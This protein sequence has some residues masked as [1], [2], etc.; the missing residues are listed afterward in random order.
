[1]VQLFAS[2]HLHIPHHL[3]CTSTNYYCWVY[4][5]SPLKLI[6]SLPVLNS[7]A[8]IVP[9]IISFPKSA[10]SFFIRLLHS[11]RE[12]Q[13]S[14][15]GWQEV[16][17]LSAAHSLQYQDSDVI[18]RGSNAKRDTT[19]CGFFLFQHFLHFFHSSSSFLSELGNTAVL[20]SSNLSF[21]FLKILTWRYCGSHWDIMS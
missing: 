6:I 7:V 14:A 16:G 1:M 19:V 20:L 10:M 21:R 15:R 12:M 17:T 4:I 8:E 5:T 3:F 13:I 2:V 11:F 18:R 9:L